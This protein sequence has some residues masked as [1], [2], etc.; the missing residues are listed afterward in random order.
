VRNT[1]KKLSQ[2]LVSFSLSMRV[3]VLFLTLISYFFGMNRIFLIG[4]QFV[5]PDCD[6]LA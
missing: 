1:P 4:C 5:V 3:R 2:L 6:L